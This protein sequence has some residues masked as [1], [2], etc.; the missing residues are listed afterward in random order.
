MPVKPPDVINDE[1]VPAPALIVPAPVIL[2]T[3]VN[4]LVVGT[5]KPPFA[6][7]IPLNVPAVPVIPPEVFNDENVPA[8]ALIFPAPVIFPPKVNVELDDKV[9]PPFAVNIP[10]NVPAVP[11]KLVVVRP[12]FAVN[13]PLNVPAAPVKPPDVVNDENVPAPALIVP[14]P[15]ILPPK[16]KDFPV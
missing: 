7:N 12:P 16:T 3:R 1:N 4:V 13:T 5:V 14:A 6:V 9:K 11:V 2:P 10:L 8:P 15:V